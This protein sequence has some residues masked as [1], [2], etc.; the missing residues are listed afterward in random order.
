MNNVEKVLNERYSEFF[1]EGNLSQTMEMLSEKFEK[2]VNHGK[3]QGMV[4]DKQSEKD[5]T[6]RILLEGVPF[7][8]LSKLKEKLKQYEESISEQPMLLAHPSGVENKDLINLFP[9]Y[10][11]K[12]ILD[13]HFSFI[14]KKVYDEM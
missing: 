3:S 7:V 11:V 4:L 13:K 12:D 2:I 10:V 9:S 14:T 5:L 1:Y 8:I 6:H